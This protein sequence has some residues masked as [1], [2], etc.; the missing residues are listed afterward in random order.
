MIEILENNPRFNRR[1][2]PSDW[3]FSASIVGMIRFFEEKEIEFDL[4]EDGFYLYYNYEDISPDND[5]KYFDYVEKTYHDSLHHTILEDLIDIQEKSDEQLKL[6]KDK[7]SG[8]TIMKKVLKGLNAEDE[9][10]ILEKISENREDIIRDTFKNA[11]FGYAKFANSNKIRSE[12]GKVCRLNGYYVDTSKKNKSV[13]FEFDNKTRNYNDFIEF[14]YIPFAFSQDRES[15]F[16]N[17][18]ISIRHLK[19]SNDAL[20]DENQDKKKLSYKL[21]KNFRSVI[22][23]NFQEA[24][25]FIDYD[26]EVILK[27]QDNDYFETIFVRKEA[28]GIFEQISKI[29]SD[30]QYIQKALKYNIKINDDYYIN[31]LNYVTNSVLNLQ[32]L[33]KLIVFLFRYKFNIKSNDGKKTENS[34]YGFLISQLIRINKL[35][36]RKLYDGGDNNMTYKSVYETAEEVKRKLKEG[37][38]ENKLGSY[39]SKLI[40]ALTAND[41][42]RFIIVLLNLSSYSQVQFDFLTLLTK[43][44]DLYKNIAFDFVSKLNYFEENSSN[45][46][47]DN[48]NQNE[49]E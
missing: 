29:D 9:Q 48:T 12:K 43:D 34:D 1:I 44:F 28:V 21:N 17:N 46:P 40:G 24:S 47:S 41:K 3:R 5:S 31:I 35:I 33:D 6:I 37:N 42:D 38:M 30:K 13:G 19:N 18:N 11:E 2:C 45:K 8:N 25:S 7:M 20:V 49:G 23:Y 14:D 15:I 36:Y 26:V 22:F 27:N 16:I 4:S 10:S 39:R 32:V